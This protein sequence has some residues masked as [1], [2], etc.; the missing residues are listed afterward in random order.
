MKYTQQ[1]DKKLCSSLYKFNKQQ[2]LNEGLSRDL[3]NKAKGFV[4]N[5]VDQVK[6]LRASDDEATIE[7]VSLIFQKENE[8][9]IDT[10]KKI[11]SPSSIYVG[12]PV[13]SILEANRIL[14]GKINDRT[15]ENIKIIN[16]NRKRVLSVSDYKI[17]EAEYEYAIILEIDTLDPA[18]KKYKMEDQ[19]NNLPKTLSI[20]T[21]FFTLHKKTLLKENL[22]GIVHLLSSNSFDTDFIVYPELPSEKEE[23]IITN[24][25]NSDDVSDKQLV[26]I[27]TSVANDT[28]DSKD[29]DDEY[30]KILADKLSGSVFKDTIL[31]TIKGEKNNK[32]IPSNEPTIPKDNNVDYGEDDLDFVPVNKSNDDDTVDPETTNTEILSNLDNEDEDTTHIPV[33]PKPSVDDE[34]ISSEKTLDNTDTDINTDINTDTT[35]IDIDNNTVEKSSPIIEPAQKNKSVSKLKTKTKPETEPV[36]PPHPN[37]DVIDMIV[38]NVLQK[39]VTN[40]EAFEGFT[41]VALKPIRSKTKAEKQYIINVLTD[42]ENALLTPPPVRTPRRKPT[43][44][45]QQNLEL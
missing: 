42:I 17:F 45:D 44:P 31:A 2:N 40:P 34:N 26:Q 24:A 19:I 36:E 37:E 18:F 4:N 39:L 35:N 15:L 13:V 23:E 29:V 38:R 33:T 27:A 3:L 21:S 30:L 16:K 12:I 14:S 20:V 5:V 28:F 32:K 22:I 43:N 9:I 1:L 11:S 25:I 41:K 7:N 8:R 10:F 6:N